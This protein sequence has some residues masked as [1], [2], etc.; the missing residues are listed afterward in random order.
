MGF[1]SGG[2]SFALKCFGLSE[3]DWI[4]TLV[5]PGAAP[6]ESTATTRGLG[7]SLDPT[8]P[9]NSACNIFR[10]GGGG[11]GEDCVGVVLC[12]YQVPP[13]RAQPWARALFGEVEAEVVVAL[14]AVEIDPGR[15]GGWDGARLLATSQAE[16]SA[17]CLE[18]CVIN[19]LSAAVYVL[20]Y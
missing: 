5:L 20:Q 12:G 3:V 18:V 8:D 6:A 7:D 14:T 13:S 17:E 2:S 19:I 11:N 10:K 15:C 9:F 1:G 4:G 16:E